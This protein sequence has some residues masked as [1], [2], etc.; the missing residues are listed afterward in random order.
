MD[1]VT[2]QTIIEAAS[3]WVGMELTDDELKKTFEFIDADGSNEIDL[4]EYK[5]AFLSSGV[6][7]LDHENGESEERSFDG[8]DYG[9]P[10]R[11]DMF[12]D[13]GEMT[14]EDFEQVK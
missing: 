2:Y 4:E 5:Q 12:M 3:A 8:D 13:Q 14:N 9:G 1:I 7:Q 11:S 6:V 10:S